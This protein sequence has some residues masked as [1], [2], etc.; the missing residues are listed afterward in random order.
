MHNLSCENEFYLHENEKPFPCQRLSTKPRFDTEA[1]GNSEL[2]Y[3]FG[4]LQL[5]SNKVRC[6]QNCDNHGPVVLAVGNYNI[7]KMAIIFDL[8]LIKIIIQ[9]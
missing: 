8:I 5:P 6:K 7:F 1:R 3:R 2:A 4:R 9:I